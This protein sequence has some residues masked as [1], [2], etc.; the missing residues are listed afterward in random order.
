ML[1]G[2]LG[3]KRPVRIPADRA[4]SVTR[5][6]LPRTPRSSIAG[7]PTTDSSDLTSG[8]RL[9]QNAKPLGGHRRRAREQVAGTGIAAD[10]TDQRR[11][12]RVEQPLYLRLGCDELTL[13]AGQSAMQVA[14]RYSTEAF[15]VLSN[16]VEKARRKRHKAS[17]PLVSLS[18]DR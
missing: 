15:G 9:T 17:G 1:A 7:T 11:G 12:E 13:V 16:G 10:G 8:E 14:R 18:H 6:A 2:H 5:T 4:P 3:S